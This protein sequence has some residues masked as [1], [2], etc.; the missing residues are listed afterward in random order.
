MKALY[1]N[2]VFSWDFCGDNIGIF[3]SWLWHGIFV[4][5]G[6]DWPIFW[7]FM[8]FS[9]EDWVQDGAPQICLL[10]YKPL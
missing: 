1:L 2:R 7:N 3:F 4:F 5:G 10:V 8:G 9:D 6:C